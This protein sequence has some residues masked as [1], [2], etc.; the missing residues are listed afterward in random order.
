MKLIV[1]GRKSAE[2][3]ALSASVLT[4]ALIVPSLVAMPSPGHAQTARPLETLP[5]VDVTV[6]RTQRPARPKRE[7][8]RTAARPQ[9]AAPRPETPVRGTDPVSG[10]VPTVSSA[11]TK[12]DTPLLET[13]Q[14]VSVIGR[15]ELDARSANTVIEGLQYTAGVSIQPGGKDPRYDNVFIRGFDINGYGNFRDG[16]RELGNPSFFALFRNEP[17]GLERIDVVKGPSAM[18]YGQTS[19]GG[20][21]DLI[22]KRPTREPFGEVVGLVG[23]ADRLQGAFDIGGPLTKD[24]TL[25]YRLTGVMRDGDAQIAHFSNFVKDNR[26]YIAPALTWQP[27][28][29][30]TFTI[31]SDYQHDVTGN[32]FPLSMLTVKPPF[33]I[34]NV[35]ALPLFLG[36]PSFNRFDQEQYRI[37]YQLEHRFNEN[38]IVRSN[39]RFGHVDLDYRYL[40]FAGVPLD[41]TTSFAR[42]SRQIYEST[43]SFTMDNHL[44]AK[45]SSGPLLHTILV[46]TD[47]TRLGLRDRTFKGN[48]DDVPALNRLA[49]VYGVAIPTPTTP[50]MSANQ[51]TDQI[52]VYLQDQIKLQKWLLTLGVRFDKA[53]QET[54]DHLTPKKQNNDDQAFSK[55]AALSYL[56]DGGLAPYVSY[57]ESFL[58]T[59]G[60]DLIT[61]AFKPTTSQ[62][63]EG[64]VKYQP[65]RDLLVTAAIFDLTQQ[66]V[67]TQD[68]TPG[69]ICCSVQT[70]EVNSRGFEAEMKAKV[71]PGLNII[72]S[73]TMQDVTVTKSND[74]DVGKVPL[75]VPR[76]MASAF[77]DYTFQ[78]GAL[79]G[80]GFGAGVRYN[81]ETFADRPNTITNAAYTVF[82][83]GLHY[84]VDKGM[85]FAL[86]VKNIADRVVTACTTNGGC[87]FT[88][89][90]TVTATASYRW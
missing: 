35:T 40:T 16:L 71:Y 51:D 75:L 30:T 13:P 27:N 25:L 14:S 8:T 15:N 11:A 38:L 2:R 58:P 55:R 1:C 81:G 87:Q 78:S 63:Y 26:A 43:D 31:L 33:T 73:Y 52:G 37:G 34:T 50:L 66:N 76:H 45:T 67:L 83:A 57:S 59:I 39:A 22:S 56:F 65:N 21:F 46:G 70:G 9:P 90:R 36:D 10:F 68:P 32:A 86:N 54:N 23:S 88:S 60:F 7:A 42:V 18:L 84:R 69:N 24:S 77:A 6:R 64:G 72:A 3:A 80:F 49:P 48:D 44:I 5:P 62:Q 12:T 79:A 89:P 41:T 74:G 4:A 28:A 47:Y 82:D 53:T 17:Y 20:L 29:N 85:S 19:P 61:S